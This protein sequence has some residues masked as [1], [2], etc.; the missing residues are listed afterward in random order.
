[1]MATETKPEEVRF[2]V[3]GLRSD[4]SRVIL[5]DRATKDDA[6]Y[7]LGL[8]RCCKTYQRVFCEPIKPPGES[9]PLPRRPR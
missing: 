4:G 9:P 7:T 6:A 5:Q 1:M 3:V 8:V 2:R